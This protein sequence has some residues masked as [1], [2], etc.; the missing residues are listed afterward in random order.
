MFSKIYKT[1]LSHKIISAIVV[2]A[3]IGGGY[4]WY[5][6]SKSGATVTKYVIE[7]ATQGTVSASVTGSG[8]TQAV[9]QI[10]VKPQVTETVTKV[11]VKVGDHV[12]AGQLLVTLDTTNEAKSVE[13]AQLSLQSAQLALAKLQE[14]PTAVS[15]GQNQDAVTMARENLSNASTTLEKDYQSGLNTIGSSFVDFQNVMTG[16][17]DFVGGTEVNKSQSNPDAY[18]NLMPNYLQAS[19]LPYRNDVN[20]HFA[21]AE[22]AYTQDLADYHATSRSADETA[23]D[24]LFSETYATAKLIN[25]NVNSVKAMLNFIINNYPTNIGLAPLPT[26]TTTYQTNLGSY[27]NTTNS[28]ISNLSDVINTVVSDKTSINNDLLSL[29]EASGTLAQLIAGTDPLNIQSQQLSIRQAELS[30]Q[31]AQQQLD[32]CYVRA[33]IGGLISAVNAVVGETVSSPAISMVGEGQVAELTLNEVDATK[34]TMDDPATLIFD[35]IS[36]LSLAGK[37]VEIDPVGTVSQGVVNYNVQVSFNDTTNQIKPGMSATAVIITKV[38]QNVIAV[39]NSAVKTRNSVSYVLVPA[40]TVTDADISA[41]ANGGIV[42]S[43]AP[44]QVAVTVGL[45]NDSM[46]EVVSG[47]QAGDPFIVQAVTSAASS[48]STASVPGASSVGSLGRLLGGG[49]APGR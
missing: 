35:A 46:T 44:K 38:D 7:K 43:A 42:L 37:V 6:A 27:T 24:N 12:A 33:P 47:L 1:I 39:P 40:G 11:S 21:A 30:V 32:D 20:S 2:L 28:D 3:V 9:T 16:L 49:G 13:Q 14:A 25:E 18:V 36:G 22:A 8:Q 45:S 31:N 17:Q 5:N 19:T 34:V 48:A 15:L 26:I 41:S 4:Y 29:N 23:L 10:N